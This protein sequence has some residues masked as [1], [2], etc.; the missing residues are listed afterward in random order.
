MQRNPGFD[1]ANLVVLK[2]HHDGV[3]TYNVQESSLGRSFTPFNSHSRSLRR[4][5]FVWLE[6]GG[7][8]FLFKER[9]FLIAEDAQRLPRG[10]G[11]GLGDSPRGTV[12][13]ADWSAALPW[14]TRLKKRNQIAIPELEAQR[15]PRGFGVGRG[16]SPRRSR[17]S[18]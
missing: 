2:R 6:S 13:W 15:V 12:W 11:V 17:S 8:F 5:L 7:P 16:E 9:S 18:L 1:T 3:T 14:W 10:V 4:I